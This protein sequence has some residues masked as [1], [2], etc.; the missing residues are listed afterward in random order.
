MGHHRTGCLICGKA[1]QYF[2]QAKIFKCAKC[3]KEFESTAACEDGHFVCDV[4]HSQAG[5]ES[6]SDYALRAES[7]NPVDIAN[8]MMENEYINM[9]GPEHHYLIIAA[10]LAA[11]KNAGGQI[12][13]EKLLAK[14]KERAGKVPGGVCGFWGCCGAGVG[15]GIFISLITGATPLSEGEWGLANKMTSLSLDAI[16]Q[17]GGPRCCKRDTY[18][19]ILS[20]IDFVK[21]HFKVELEKPVTIICNFFTNNPSCKKEECRFYPKKES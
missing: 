1:L 12:D 7:K 18:L 8:E 21:E 10:L 3:G 14:A 4:C 17:K 20:A 5:S 15:S 16:S 13:L 2:D 11:Y 9:H 19:A 6:V